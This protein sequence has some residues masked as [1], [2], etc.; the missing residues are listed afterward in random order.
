MFSLGMVLLAHRYRFVLF[1]GKRLVSCSRAYL[2][3]HCANHTMDNIWYLV[4][5]ELNGSVVI[6]DCW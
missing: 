2:D 3:G 5:N 1:E 4:L 6:A